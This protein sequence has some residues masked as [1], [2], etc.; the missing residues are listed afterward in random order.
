MQDQELTGWFE[1]SDQ[2]PWEPG[3]YEIKEF[4][5]GERYFSYWCGK[6]FHGGWLFIDRAM[7]CKNPTPDARQNYWRGLSFDPNSKP[8]PK[9]KRSGNPTVTRYVVI[10]VMKGEPVA[11]LQTRDAAVDYAARMEWP[12]IKRVRHRSP[13]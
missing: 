12:R 5:A 13:E 10:D 4:I 6:E 7:Q 8:G 1:L 3:V 11:S 2:K 9:P